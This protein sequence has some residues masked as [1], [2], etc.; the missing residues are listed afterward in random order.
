MQKNLQ[1]FLAKIVQ[2]ASFS[3]RLSKVKI[4]GPEVFVSRSNKY[5][6]KIHNSYILYLYIV[7]NLH[8]LYIRFKYIVFDIYCMYEV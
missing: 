8:I 1:N 7:Y 4:Q 5:T 3:L 2:S 6:S